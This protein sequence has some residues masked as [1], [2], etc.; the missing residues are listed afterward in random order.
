MEVIFRLISTAKS[1]QSIKSMTKN[2]IRFTNP[3]KGFKISSDGK[4]YT[5]KT[6]ELDP[7][8]YI[9]TVSEND[10]PDSETKII[11]HK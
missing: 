11:I 10:K 9:I 5:D 2:G 8:T 3:A 7:G 1:T 6:H 4:V